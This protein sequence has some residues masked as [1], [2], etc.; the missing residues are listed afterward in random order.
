MVKRAASLVGLLS[1]VVSS[2]GAMGAAV[3][4]TGTSS[5]PLLFDKLADNAI[6]TKMT[7][8]PAMI[9]PTQLLA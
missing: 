4:A 1:L 6:M 9:H 8:A 5:L 3:V 7:T 2:V